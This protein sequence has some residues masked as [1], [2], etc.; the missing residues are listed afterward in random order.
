[1]P[2]DEEEKNVSENEVV[3]AN[4]TLNE[5]PAEN[6]ENA[7]PSS[8]K[9]ETE[10]GKVE[11][12]TKPNLNE[13]DPLKKAEYSFHKQFS[14]QKRKYEDMLSKQKSDYDALVKRLEALENPVQVKGRNDFENDDSY[15]DYLVSERVNKL[16]AEKE[17]SWNK[18]KLEAE[19]KAKQEASENE[20]INATIRECFGT[21]EAI[22]DYQEK[23]SFA[24]EQGLSELIDGVP[25][26]SNYIQRSKSGPKILYK[27]ATDVDAVNAL[28]EGSPDEFD[29]QLR[30]R[31]LEKTINKPKEEPRP[32]ETQKVVEPPKAIGKPGVSVEKTT[33][34]FDD[35]KALRNFIRKH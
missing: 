34:I 19:E 14:R 29:L 23:V 28:F 13:I 8:Q 2:I 4:E 33:D 30:I 15:I 16:L 32:I 18:Q 10:T 1:M 9:L 5:T 12:E 20:R 25:A 3:T 27:L 17:E 26:L 24:F 6:K 35:Q 7:E 11:T 21:D 31:D 22:K